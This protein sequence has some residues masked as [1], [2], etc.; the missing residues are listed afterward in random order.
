MWILSHTVTSWLS[1]C[2]SDTSENAPASVKR[3]ATVL[4]AT[5]VNRVASHMFYKAG[6]LQGMTGTCVLIMINPKAPNTLSN[7]K[8][9]L[10]NENGDEPLCFPFSS[11]LTGPGISW[12]NRWRVIFPHVMRRQCPI[13]C[14]H[15]YCF[16]HCFILFLLSGAVYK[17]QWK[18]ALMHGE[19][20]L[21][22]A[23]GRMYAGQFCDGE[24]TG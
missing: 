18:R 3:R 23:D 7:P 6:L 16:S 1:N 21:T 5:P 11:L 12:N 9:L 19:G 15:L 24:Q 13:A 20:Q 10:W 14:I 2:K 17:G 8:N 4:R 22:W